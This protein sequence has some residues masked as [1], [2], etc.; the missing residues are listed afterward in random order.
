MARRYLQS[1]PQLPDFEV[2]WCA[3]CNSFGH[4]DSTTLE[5][6]KSA[7]SLQRG[8]DQQEKDQD[9]DVVMEDGFSKELTS[10]KSE[11]ELSSFMTEAKNVLGDDKSMK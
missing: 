1:I 2:S 4:A 3:G 6:T 9:G 7:A 5:S 11:S 10:E 8:L